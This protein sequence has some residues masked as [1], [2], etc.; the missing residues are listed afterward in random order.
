MMMTTCWNGVVGVGG[1]GVSVGVNVGVRVRAR[2]D[3]GVGVT[4]DVK[5]GVNVGRSVGVAVS[6]TVGEA[7]AVAVNVAV[8]VAVRRPE[9]VGVPLGVMVTKLLEAGGAAEI[10]SGRVN[11]SAI[12]PMV[13]AASAA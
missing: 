3:A 11:K 6:V 8:E 7:V 1:T 4:V 9:G 13:S 10:A 12:T 2:V 5:V